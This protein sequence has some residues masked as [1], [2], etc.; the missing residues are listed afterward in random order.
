VFIIE[1]FIRKRS[2]FGK[3]D[4]LKLR[5]LTTQLV[6]IIADVLW[7]RIQKQSATT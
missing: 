7:L 5:I 6:E 4:L 1:R 3:S 2:D